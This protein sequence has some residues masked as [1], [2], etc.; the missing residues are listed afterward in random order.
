MKTNS[1]Q[2]RMGVAVVWSLLL[3]IGIG[4][5]SSAQAQYDRNRRG[6]NWDNYGNYGGSFQLRQTALNAGYNEGLKDGTAARSRNRNANYTDQNSYR[7]ATKDY[8]SRLGD[9]EIYRRYFREAYE[10]GFRDGFNPG[11]YDNSSNNRDWN[12][13]NRDRDQGNRDWDRGNRPWDRNR[14]GNWDPNNRRG[15]NW[16]RYGTYGGSSDLRQTALNAGYNEG[17]K[18]GRDDRGRGS[19]EDFRNNSKYREATTDYSSR[20]GDRELYRRYYRE[21]YENGYYDGL[22]GN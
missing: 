10:T 16:D 22:N 11:G 7:R 1:T 5:G 20:L 2:V 18:E 3:I 6:R 4:L 13:G 17:I 19:R 15:R 21:G 14:D 9:R 8:S 12:R